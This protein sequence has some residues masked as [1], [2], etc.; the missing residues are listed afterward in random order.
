MSP[1]LLVRAPSRHPLRNALLATVATVA[2]A[3]PLASSLDTATA[4]TGRT[5]NRLAQCESGVIGIS[6]LATAITVACSSALALG[7]ASVAAATP[8]GPILP[9]GLSR[10]SSPRRCSTVRAGVHGLPVRRH[11]GSMPQMPTPLMIGSWATT[12]T[13]GVATPA[14]VVSM[15]L[16]CAQSSCRNTPR[17]TGATLPGDQAPGGATARQSAVPKSRGR[18]RNHAAGR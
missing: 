8:L 7:S 4:A 6:T 9:L 11:S 16:R 1:A 13:H 14:T 17:A 10:S 5:W 15:S 3:A 12:S 18:E 2:V